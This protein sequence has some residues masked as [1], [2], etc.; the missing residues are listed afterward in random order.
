MKQKFILSQFFIFLTLL[1]ISNSLHAGFWGIPDPNNDPRNQNPFGPR[2]PSPSPSVS[3]SPNQ[4]VNIVPSLS[5]SPNQSVN[6]VPSPSPD[7]LISNATN[8]TTITSTPSIT[9]TMIPTLTLT[10]THTCTNMPK[11]YKRNISSFPIFPFQSPPPPL[12]KTPTPIPTLT[13]SRTPTVSLTPTNT[14]TQTLTSSRTPI[15]TSSFTMTPTISPTLSLSN[16]RTVSL[17]PTNTYNRTLSM[18]NDTFPEIIGI[19]ND[20][21]AKENLTSNSANEVESSNYWSWLTPT[22]I[23]TGVIVVIAVIYTIGF[24]NP[25]PI[26][27]APINPAPI[28]MTTVNLMQEMQVVFTP[29]ALTAA[30]LPATLAVAVA[31]VLL[32]IAKTSEVVIDF[33]NPI[34]DVPSTQYGNNLNRNDLKR[35]NSRKNKIIFWHGLIKIKNLFSFGSEYTRANTKSSGPASSIS[36]QVVAGGRQCP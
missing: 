27:P 19:D 11:F 9:L 16:T 24:Y 10:H 4:N 8:T 34:S 3:P 13:F 30:T 23:A 26:N 7:E 1:Y 32:E 12:S 21:N 31:V 6:I 36:T 18:V 20:T 28:L 29:E 35:A 2:N 33:E 14:D 22:L 25:A 17:T 5:P 15:G